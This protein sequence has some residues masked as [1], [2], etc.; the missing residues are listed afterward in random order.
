MNRS[1]LALLSLALTGCASTHKPKLHGDLFSELAAGD[2]VHIRFGSM[3]CFH[4]YGYDFDFER[5]AATT[6]RITSL[7]RSWSAATKS[8]EYRSPKQLGTLTLTSRDISGLDGL[9]RYY[10]THPGGACTTMDDITIEHF[11]R[12]YGPSAPAMATEH[13]L[14]LS[15]ATS[16]LPGVTTLP[17]LAKR[18]D[19]KSQ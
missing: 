2:R 12:S 1:I 11:R 19:P 9:V 10:R 6:V 17:S 18:L 14:D 16:E 3:G 15:C 4:S 8:F 13:Y 5:S 7:S